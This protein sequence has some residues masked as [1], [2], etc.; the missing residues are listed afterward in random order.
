L[1]TAHAHKVAP[2]SIADIGGLIV[3]ITPDG[4]YDVEAKL[5]CPE[6]PSTWKATA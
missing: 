3:T 2:E 1:K 4:R 5:Y 6:L